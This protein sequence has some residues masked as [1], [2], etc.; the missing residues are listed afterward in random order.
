MDQAAD[1]SE[2][3]RR[4]EELQREK[5]EKQNSLE[6]LLRRIEGLQYGPFFVMVSCPQKPFSSQEP[7]IFYRKIVPPFSLFSVEMDEKVDLVEVLT[8][9][10]ENLQRERDELRKDIEQLCMQQA[11]PGYVSVATR[12]LT[13]RT[14]ALE[15]DIEN[16]QKKL[17][18]C[19]RENQNLQEELAEAYRI[20]SQLAE[21][22]GAALSKVSHF[23][24]KYVA[25]LFN[26]L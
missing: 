6:L 24:L 14:A 5:D 7:N 2:L 19:L 13:Q 8:R 1:S 22:H 4:I 12:M 26:K 15:Q 18:G 17:G 25:I 9:Q 23:D 11:G 20:K 3:L 21:L 16:L 10:V